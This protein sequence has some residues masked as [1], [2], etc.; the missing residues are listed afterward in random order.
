MVQLLQQ[1]LLFDE[2]KGLKQQSAGHSDISC[3]DSI[4]YPLPYVT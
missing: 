1:L 2:M 4:F 3:I